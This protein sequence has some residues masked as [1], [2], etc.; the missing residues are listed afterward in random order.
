[1]GKE[2]ILIGETRSVCPE[3]LLRIPARKIQYGDQVYLEKTC[4]DH[5]FFKT[6][7]WNG[8][9]SYAAWGRELK[10]VTPI[11][12]LSAVHQGCPYDCGICPQHG[13]HTCCVLFEITDR[14]NL[15]CPVCF[16]SS[17]QGVPDDPDLDEISSWYDMLLECGGPFNI[18]LSGGEPSLR[19]D[20]PEIIRIGRAKGFPFFQ[21]NTNGLRLSR[22]PGYAE[23]LKEAGLDCVF[24]QFDT[25][26]DKIYEDLRGVALLEDKL[27]AIEHCACAGLGVV[28]VPVLLAGINDNEIGDI[29]EFAVRHMPSVRGVH[30]QPIS[31]FG[32]YPDKLGKR[33]TIPDVLRN[34]ELQTHHKMQVSDFKPGTAEHPYCSFNGSYLLKPDGTLKSSKKQETCC[35]GQEEPKDKKCLNASEKARSYV[36]KRWS[37]APMPK[38]IM[39]RDEAPDS[40]D[41]ML[42]RIE[43]Y[44]LAVSGMAFQDAWNLDLE[45]LRY[46]YIHVVSKDTRLIPFCAYNLTSWTGHSLYRGK[47]AGKRGLAR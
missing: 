10:P 9:P 22:E 2:P 35:C 14:C 7:I 28:L 32:R 29:L 12:C 20:I 6:L 43:Q 13:Q 38:D 33:L 47:E 17:T 5:G 19:D 18:Q 36:A 23:V 42:T 34:I 46:C 3:C 11:G 37:H 8:P 31:Y 16:A 26:H 25:F 4:P 41:A 15:H 21:L 30:F 27:R 24:L 45:R 44:S 39:P 40:F 1:M